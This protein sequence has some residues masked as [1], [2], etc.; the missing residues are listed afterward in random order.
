[1]SNPGNYLTYGGYYT[2]GTFYNNKHFNQPIGNWQIHTG[3]DVYMQDIFA[4]TRD[5]NQPISQSVVTVGTSSY[6]AW[7]VKDVKR[8]GN[9]TLEILTRE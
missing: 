5:F 9:D 4:R 6:E 3:S 8:F 7:N 2:Q 1:M